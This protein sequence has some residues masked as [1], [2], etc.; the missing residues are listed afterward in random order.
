MIEKIW[1]NNH[2]LKYLLWPLL[3]PLS[4]LFKMISTQRRSAYR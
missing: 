1:F 2:P 4:L 3:W